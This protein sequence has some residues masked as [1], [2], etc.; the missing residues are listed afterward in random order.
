MTQRIAALDAP[1]SPE[2]AEVLAA[3]MP[4]GAAPIGLFRTFAHN[5]PMA[6]AM[7]GWGSYE[8]SKRLSLSMREREVVIDRTCARAGCEYEWGVHIAFFAERVGFTRAQISS[9][10]YGQPDDGCWSDVRDRQLIRAADELHE[11]NT[12]SDELF[13]QLRVDFTD[14][15]LLDLALLAGWYHAISYSARVA[16][17]TLE[18][19]APT[20]ES[21]RPTA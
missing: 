11:T 21:V 17:V 10:T 1:Y 13:E 20:F 15:Q 6:S 19:G 9:L 5:L 7:T 4:P 8:L 3:M 2:Q 18:P 14:A 16:G 12:I